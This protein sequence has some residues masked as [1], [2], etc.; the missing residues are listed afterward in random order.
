MQDY[1]DN[2]AAAQLHQGG[3]CITYRH[4]Y[5]EREV[6][7][8]PLRNAARG[9]LAIVG[10]RVPRACAQSQ[11]R[12]LEPP[13]PAHASPPP[14]AALQ[15]P[16]GVPRPRLGASPPVCVLAVSCAPLLEAWGCAEAARGEHAIGP[17]ADGAL[18]TPPLAAQ[19]DDGPTTTGGRMV[20]STRAARAGKEERSAALRRTLWQRVRCVLL[21]EVSGPRLLA[22]SQVS[23]P[24]QRRRTGDSGSPLMRG[25]RDRDGAPLVEANAHVDA[26]RQPLRCGERDADAPLEDV[27]AA[28]RLR[29]ASAALVCPS[30]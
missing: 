11:R 6:V 20:R 5:M 4:G 18:A 13:Q 7:V 29:P 1:L 21:R 30:N 12:G 19:A 25:D 28:A 17:A 26:P 8:E 9:G 24:C 16:H 2:S 3:C 22:A 10:E 27:N 23:D 14:C 15:P